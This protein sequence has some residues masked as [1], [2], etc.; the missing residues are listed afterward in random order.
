MSELNPYLNFLGDA[1]AAIEFYHSVFGGELTINT[2]A[3]FGADVKDSELNLVMHSQLETPSGY[4]LM[5]SDTP[6]HIEVPTGPKAFS[7]SISGLDSENAELTGYFEALAEGGTVDQPLTT[8]PWG[9]SFG[10]LTD[11]FGVS[12]LVNIAGP[13]A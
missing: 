11:K 13:Q 10:M 8:S 7:I 3:D 4:V 9:A 12:W 6:S 1:R 2:F 5:A